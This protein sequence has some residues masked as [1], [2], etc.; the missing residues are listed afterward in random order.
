MIAYAQRHPQPRTMPTQSG[1]TLFSQHSLAP[2]RPE[3]TSVR[4]F[5]G[6][7]PMRAL[8]HKIAPVNGSG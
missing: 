8:A 6:S 3:M 1:K 2:G 5:S 7:P 4:T